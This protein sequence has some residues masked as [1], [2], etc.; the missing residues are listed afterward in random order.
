MTFLPGIELCRAFYHEV[1]APIVAEAFPALA[2]AAALIGPGSEVLGF[3][4]ER[5]TDHHWGPRLL[6]FLSNA[7]HVAHAQALYDTLAQR[8]PVSFRGYP[9][10]WGPPD[11]Y[12]V[13]LLQAVEQGPVAHRVDVE[14]LGA[15][16]RDVLGFDPRNGVDLADWLLTPSQ[17]LLSVTAGAVYHDDPGD[18]TRVRD[19]LAW[20][21]H[22]VWLYL[23]AAA[24][25]RIADG[26]SF[27][28]R[29]AEVGDHLGSRVATARLA[30]EV[31]RLCLLLERRYPPYAKW[32]GTAF[33]QLP[34]AS[35]VGPALEAA[36]AA[37][38][39]PEREA[40]LVTAYKAVAAL[41]NASGNTAPLDPDP[42]PYW[43]R[44]YRVLMA[45]RFAGATHAAIQDE[46]VR[47]LPRRLG[48]IDHLT[49]NT[50]VLEQPTLARRFAAAYGDALPPADG[51]G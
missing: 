17:R 14:P 15:W 45:G 7:D 21:P 24:W 4:S 19:A 49:D 43:S 29:T 40:Q 38:T 23:I 44:P 47:A 18:L 33:A 22:D 8:L 31:M 48:S 28:G 37:T 13:C 50:A 42:R 41:H 51:A 39:W 25:S 30:R 34:I 32:L 11:E 46:R 20:Y 26:E 27:P 9:T 2:Y 10:N 3:D 35:V 16:L 6:L 1:V 36:C 12:G 5:S